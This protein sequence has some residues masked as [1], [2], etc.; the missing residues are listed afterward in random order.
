MRKVKSVL[1]GIG[2]VVMSLV[3]ILTGVSVAHASAADGAVI[4]QPELAV[5]GAS[6]FGIAAGVV[7]ALLVL[8]TA[9]MLI[10]NRRNRD[11]TDA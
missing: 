6:G 5:T 4:A 11:E 3:L 2:T 1:T 8:G 9:L 7:A 10:R